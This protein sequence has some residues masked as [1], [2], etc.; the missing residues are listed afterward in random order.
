MEK[1][2]EYFQ[3]QEEEEQ[4]KTAVDSPN[5]KEPRGHVGR[6]VLAAELT[7][8]DVSF[9]PE[10]AS[11]VSSNFFRSASSDHHHPPNPA[12]LSFI[13]EIHLDFLSCVPGRS[14]LR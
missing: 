10:P 4:E 2:V 9:E 3:L 8:T 7:P 6:A 11:S 13:P 12:A 5:M 1:S 14:P